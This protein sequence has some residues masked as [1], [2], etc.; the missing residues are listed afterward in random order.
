MKLLPE[1]ET[2]K[3]FM[4]NTLPF[5]FGLAW[6]PV[7]WVIFLAIF[8]Q[9]LAAIIGWSATLVFLGIITLICTFLLLRFFRRIAHN[10][11]QKSQ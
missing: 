4:K 10:L 8:A 6:M 2:R 11:Y 3:T 1:K 5:L 9:P 7:I